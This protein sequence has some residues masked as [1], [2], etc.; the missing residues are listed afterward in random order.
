MAGVLITPVGDVRERLDRPHEHGIPAALVD[1]QS[2]GARFPWVAVDDVL[3][4]RCATRHLLELGHHRIA[5]GILQATSED[6]G[7]SVRSAAEPASVP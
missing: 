3:G 4:G 1:R 6:G 7:T 2:E 5:F